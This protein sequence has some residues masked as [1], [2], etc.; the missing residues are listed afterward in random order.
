MSNDKV[1]EALRTSMK[2][3]ERLRKQNQELTAAAREPIA[4]VAMACR[5]PGGVR[6]PE[7]L[8]DL[9]VGERDAITEFPVNRGW[10]LDS[11][12]NDDPDHEGTSYSRE[13]GFLHDAGSFDPELFGISPREA[14]AMDPQQRL[15]LETS[16][17]SF[18][19][20]G[21]DPHSLRGNRCGVFVGLS[22][23]D[24]ATRLRKA[25]EGTEGHLLTGNAGAVASGRLSY[26]FG[27]E[28][29]AVTVDTACSSSLVALHLACQAL[30]QGDCSMALAGGVTVMASPAAFVAFSRQRG[31]AANGRCK[32]FS[33]Y[34]DGTGWSEG[35]G[36]VLVERLS[37]ARRN[38]HPVLAVVRGTGVN[39]DGASSGLTAPNGPSQQRVIKQ[40]LSNA[41]LS[42]SDVDAVE[43]HGTGTVLGD[44]IEAQ[45]VLATY[46]Q[47]RSEDHPLWL[48]SLKS[49][50]GHAQGAAGVAGVIK[51]VLATQHGLLPKTLHV[52]EP[53]PQVD[54]TAGS[55]R[56]LTEAMPW[57]DT[58]RPRRAGVSSFG[59]SGTNAHA[60]VEQAPP[61]GAAEREP[62]T[63][64]SPIVAWPVSGQTENGLR[65]QADRLAGYLDEHPELDPV[66]VG[67][68]L[69]TTRAA[70]NHRAVV[71]AAN[72]EDF[73]RAL[74]ALAEGEPAPEVVRGAKGGGRFAIQF[75]GQGSQR[76]G[77]GRELHAT[78]PVFAAAFDDVCAHLDLHLDRPVR[79]VV[80][81]ADEELANQTAYAQAGLFAVEVALFRLVEH[82]GVLPKLLLGHSIGE[83][84][85]AHVS[86][87]LS[88][89]DACALVA[90]RGRLMQALPS[91]GAMVSL[92]AS[93]DEVAP[94]LDETVSIAAVNGPASVVVSGDED[95]VSRIAEHFAAEGR[96]TKRLRVSHAFHSPRMDAMLAEFRRAA[97]RVSFEPP[98]IPIVSNVTGEVATAEQ[99][100]S[101]GYWVD[102][103]RRAVRFRDGIRTLQA[104]G[105]TSLLELGPGGVLS[106]MGP[107]CL[108]E[109]GADEVA[110]VP[111]L[112]GG[113]PEVPALLRAIGELHVRGVSPDWRKFYAGS[114]AR[115]VDLP[116]YAF[117]HREFWLE[118]PA[119]ELGDLSAA[120]LRSAEH[121]L[122]GAA[123]SLADAEGVV[124]LGR[125]SLR[126]HPWLAD[127]AILGSVLLPGTAFVELA[128]RAGDQVGCDLV[129][130][131]TLEAPLVLGADSAVQVQLS[132]GVPDGTGRRTVTVYSREEDGFEGEWTRHATGVLATATSGE[133]TDLS[134]WPPEGAR[135]LELDGFYDRLTESGF[136][137]GPVF[138]GLRAAW[139]RG[140]EI[141]AE[142]ALPE[143]ARAD[144]ARFGLHPGLLDAA[145]HA[146]GLEP[147]GGAGGG[148]LPFAWTGVR[149][150]ASGASSL[151]VRLSA[152]SGD[153]V[154]IAVADGSGAPVASVDALVLRPVTA[155]Q[156]DGAKGRAHRNLF[157]VDW[158]TATTTSTVDVPEPR[159][160][161]AVLGSVAAGDELP[162]V[163]AVSVNGAAGAEATTARV[164]E[165]VKAWLAA[166]RDSRLV[167]V[168]RGAVAVS[169]DAEVTDLG[170]S[171]VWGLVRAAQSEHP[172]R[173]TLVD[174]DAESAPIVVG[175]EPQVAVRGGRALVPRLVRA[176]ELAQPAAE[177]S[178]AAGGTVLVTGAGGGLGA[179]VARHV[180]AE[181]G[182]R[183][184]VLISR[185]GDRAPGAAELSAE[186]AGLGAE[187]V[188]AACDVADRDA[189]AGV[190]AAV[191]DERPL[192]GVV[193]AAGIVDDGLVGSLS[194]ERLFAVLRPKVE[195]AWNLHELTA[196]L[197]LSAFVLFSSAAGV[198]G[199]A[200][201]ANYAAANAFLDALAQH[202]RCRGLVATSLAWG[203][204]GHSGG[205]AGELSEAD[206]NRMAR[207]GVVPL[208]ADEGLELFDIGWRSAE[209]FL[210]P[211]GL[212]VTALRNR[213]T[214]DTVPPLLRNLIR[215]PARRAVTAEPGSGSSL[216]G[217]LHGLPEGE[218]GKVLLDL[219]RTQVAVVL[220]FAGAEAVSASRA[221]SEIGFDSLTAV[222]LRNRLNSVTGLR[223]P[224]T[225]IFDYP[226]P[227]VLAEFL[228]AE[229][230][231]EQAEVAGP[232]AT[233]AADGEPIA[234]VGMACRYPGGVTS[235]EDLWEL[236]FS[237]RDGITEFPVNRGWDL[238]GLYDADA[239][240][241]GTSYA[242]EGG[243]L[244]DAAEFDPAF[245]G[246]SPREAVAM[247]PQ[248]RLLLETSWE[249]F[250]RA[251]IDPATVRGSRTGVFTGVMYHD[252]AARL[253]AFPEG[254]EGYL[255]TGNAGSVASGRVSYAF[256][257]EGPAVTVD[258]ACSSSLV[259][260]H[261]AVQALRSGEC[262]LALAGGVTVMSTP[263]TFV[264]FSRQRGLARDGRCKSFAAA[265]DGTG[266]SEGVGVLLVERLSD[267]R[268]NGHPVLAVV[269]G[270]AIN[271][272]GASN[273][274][275]APNGPSQQRVIRQALAN[276]GL[277]PS[278][279][280]A[281]E[282]HGTGTVLGDPIEAQAL[283]ATYG[284]DRDE[285]L[286]LGSIKS[287]LGHSQAAAGVAGVIKMVM[288][289]RH[290]TLPRTP[291]V[292]EPSPH[293]DWSSGA[294]ELLTE[295]R[296]WQANGRPRRAGVSSFGISGTNA[297]VVLEQIEE[298][299]PTPA[300][301]NP[302]VLP[303][304]VSGNDEAA[305][306]AQA[307][308][309]LSRV[310]GDTA[311]LDVAFSLAT[312]RASFERRAVVVGTGQDELLAG[313]AA[314]SG[315]EAAQGLVEGVAAE[316]QL[317]FLFSGQGSQRLGMGREL[318]AAFPVF[319]EAFDE[320][321]AELDRHL[322]RSLREVIWGEDSELVDQTGYTQPG[323]FAV[324]VAL[325]RLVESWGVRPDYLLGHSI[326]ELAAAHVADVFSLADAARLVV[327]RGRLMQALPSGGAMVAVQAT[328]DDV[329]PLL[330]DT[331]S[332]AAINGPASVVV[333][334]DESAAL[335]VAEHFEAEGRKTKRLRVSHAFH[336]PRM[337]P[338]LA[339]FAEVAASVE[340]QAPRI[341]V[342]SNVSGQLDGE[343]A[344]P[345]Y[346]VRHVR[347]A[348]RFADG[349]RTL[350]ERGVTAFLEIGPDGVLTGLAQESL[351]ES[352]LVPALRRDRDEARALVEALG[353]LHVNG[354]AVD[355]AAWFSGSGARRIDLPTYAFQRRR[356]WLEEPAGSVGDVASAGLAAAGHPLLGAAVR[357]AERD[358]VV[359]TGRVSVRTH[360]WLAE[361]VV[362]GA[363]VVPGT[364]L[365]DMAV[366]A[367]DQI[368]CTQVA[369]LTL[370]AP[371]L[372]P[373]EGAVQLQLAV[374]AGDESGRHNLSLHARIDD[375]AGEQ[376]WTLHATGTLATGRPESPV[377][378]AAWPP[379]E[380]AALPVDEVYR[381]AAAAG[382]GYGP[383]FQGLRAVWQ[384]GEEIFAEVALPEH[385]DAG[386]F[387]LHPA[388]FDAVL[389]AL[390][391]LPGE[392]EG[393]G[394]LPFSW[395]G[396]SLHASGASALRARLS[397]TGT[398]SIA[399]DLADPTGQPVAT[400]GALRLRPV[401]PD[402][403]RAAETTRNRSLF[404]VDWDPIAAEP[405][406]FAEPRDL[407]TVLG[408]VAAGDELPEVVAVPV[409]GD[410]GAAETAAKVLELVKAWLAADGDARLVFVTSGAVTA[411]RAE[412]VADLGA[413][414]VWGLVRAA[415]SEHP[416]R[417]ALVDLDSAADGPV[418]VVPGEPQVAVRD[419]R[420]LAPRL[421]RARELAQPAAEVSFA[422]GGTVL[423]S[424]AGGGWG[425]LVAR[426]VVAE[427]GVRRLVLVSR[428][429]DG[430]PGAAE[431]SAELAGLGAEVVWAACDV[432]DR[433]ALAGVLAGIPDERPLIGVVH[434]A[435]IVDDG[436]V[437]SLSSERLAAVL[438]PKVEGARNL[439]E[440]T[441]GLDLSAFVLF[442]SVAGVFGSAGQANYAAANAYL[443]ALAQHRRCRGLVATSL[444]WGLWGHSGGMA[445][446][447]TEAD[448][449][450]M[451]RDGVHALTA[452]Q[453][454][455]L[456]DIGWR[457]AEAHLVPVGLDLLALRNRLT[458]DEVP[459]LL[460]GLIRLPA[461]RHSAGSAAADTT[462]ARRL[463]GLTAEEQ[464][465]AVVA[466]I[467]A[468]VAVVLGFAGAEAVSVSRAFSEIGFDSLTAVELRN[469]LNSVTGLRLPATLIFDYPTPLL[470]AEFVRSELVGDRV[471]VAGPVATT[472]ADDEPIAIVGMA[473][474]YPGGVSSP[475][476]LW[477]FV[478]AGGDGISA[479][480]TDRG[481]DLDGLYDADADRAGTS[482]AREGG[483]L[484]DAAEFDP[485]FF[486][487]S[488]RE[489][490][491]MDPQQRLLLETSWEA[492]ERAGID[493]ESLRGSRTGVFAGVMYSDYSARLTSVPQGVEGY[494]GTGTSAS[495]LSGRVSYT[496]G[497]E[498]PAVTVDTA[499]SSSL[500]ALHLAA[501][502][503]RSG[504]CSLAL[505]GGVTV[506]ATPGAFVEFSRQ[507]GL[508]PDGR[509]RSF[510][511][512]AD[513]VGWSEGVGVLLVER[514]SDA[515]R[516]GHQVLG[517]VRGS[518]VNQDG[519]SNGLTA[520]NGPSQQRVIRQAVASAGLELSDVDAVEAHGTGTVLG[521][522]IEAQ[523]LI[524]TYGQDREQPLWLGS[525]KSNIGHS[526]AAAG[527]AGIIKMV[528]AMRHGVLPKSLHL[529][530]P[531]P[532]VDWSAGAVELLTE[533]R[534]WPETGRA[535]R[536]AVSSFGISGTN[537][538]V[539][540]EQAPEPVAEV[541][542]G[543]APPVLPWV[544][545]AKTPEALT[546]QADRLNTFVP[547]HSPV[548]VG[549]SLAT[550]RS[551]LERRAVVVG[552][553]AEEL[554]RGLTALAQGG[555]APGVRTGTAR[556]GG[557]AVL[558]SGQGSQRLGMGRELYEAFPVFAEAFDAVCAGL[559]EHLEEPL[560]AVIWGA[561]A[562]AVHQT[563]Y[564][565]AGLFAVEVALFRLFE[566]FGV[567]P[568]YL[569]GHSIGELAAAHVAGVLALESA[570]AL[571][572][573][574]GR[575]M[576]ALPTGGAMVAVQ[577]TED[578][579]VPL[580]DDSV[581]IAAVNGPASVVVSGAEDA[582]L[583]VAERFE[584]RKTRRLR[585]SHAFHSALMEPMLAEFRRVA[586]GLTFGEPRIPLVSNVSG[587]VA[588]A[589]ELG[590]PGYWVDHVRRAVRFAEGVESL[591][592][593]GVSTF[594]E[595]GPAGVLAGM[596]QECLAEAGAE[597]GVVA[598]L[599]KDRPE[600]VALVE[601]LAGVF[602]RGVRVD[603]PVLFAGANARRVDLPTYPFQRRRYWLDAG[604][605]VSDASAAGL[606]V[607]GHPL[608]SAVVQS[609]DSDAVVLT[610]RL[611][612]HTHA[613]L[614]DHA[615]FGR[616]LVPG[617]GLVELA[618]R[619]GQQVGCDV[620]EE[621]TLRAPLTLPERGGLAVQVVVD[622]GDDSGRR[623]VHV[624]SR[625]ENSD[626]AWTLH[627]EGV[628]GS[629]AAASFELTEWPPAG[630]EAVAVEGAY[631][632]FAEQGYGYGP[633]FRG[634]RAVWRRGAELFAEVVLPERARGDAER[635]GL[636]PALLDAAMH[637]TLGGEGGSGDTV[638][639]FAWNGV[640]L[641]A[642]GA[643]AVRVRLAP[644]PDGGLRIAVADEAGQPVLS[645]DSMVGRPVSPEQLRAGGQG[646]PLYGVDW[647]PVAHGEVPQQSFVEWDEVPESGAVPE[648]VVLECAAPEDQVPDAV[649]SVLHRVL[650]AVQRWLADERFAGSRLVVLTRNAVATEPG[651]AVRLAEAPVWGLVRAAQAEN[652]GRFV[653][654][655]ADDE[656]AGALLPA[657]V[658][659]GEP[660]A[661][662]RAGRVHLPRLVRL[663]AA[664]ANPVFGATGTVLVT[665]GTG[666]LGALVARH[667]V[668]VHGVRRL[669]LTS[670]RGLDAP[671]AGELAAELAE[672][673]AEVEV[674]ACDVADREAVAALVA[675]IPDLDAVVHA[676]GIGDNGLVSALSPERVDAVLAPKADAAWYLHELTRGLDLSAFVLF[677]SAGG[678]V[679]AAG[680]ANYAAA[681]V[682]L[683]ALAAQRHADG[684]P[685]TSLA[686]G[687][688]DSGSGMGE[689]LGE[690]DRQRM[691]AQ[692]LPPLPVESALALFDAGL[693][694]DRPVVVPVRVDPS[695]L[696]SR[697]GEIPALLRGLAP[698]VRR[699][700]TAASTETTLEQRLAGLGG[701]ERQRVL[702]DLV[703]SRVAG[704]LG[705]A[706]AESIEPDRA[707][708]E[709]GFDSLAAMELRNQ[710]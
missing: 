555:T 151:R 306:R 234:I 599:R 36:M 40:A 54:W 307:A 27:L 641:F 460:R 468:E 630:A 389:H 279:V 44:P 534:A 426:H 47:G 154:A 467:A 10:D 612:L 477:D 95:A 255:G 185:R 90:A 60:I 402:Q 624:F 708:Q 423:G 221:F 684:L 370:H 688:W 507:R 396:V 250:E 107:D 590:S 697:E 625:A 613:W 557:L 121:P 443:D 573:A 319:A 676:A 206:L 157:R 172:D 80:W 414:A 355:W 42:P 381:R 74:R 439:H 156:L 188:W 106:G 520:P 655:D 135:R 529:D 647:K 692:G 212:D 545:S 115:R 383:L 245:F 327:A 171:A 301:P 236:V 78:Y 163:V 12:Y 359:L 108:D 470:L 478:L 34:A 503:L 559:D 610:G 149:L 433:D 271:Q 147:S 488:P 182:V 667:L 127:H 639:P 68:S 380:A 424:G 472:A 152:A 239:D 175:S 6:S 347:E 300:A 102:H 553:D 704:V 14:L 55:V 116:P 273:G 386:R 122:L 504:E 522:P 675:R 134:V 427:H 594:V 169:A 345:E 533:T 399:L 409:G 348:V 694:A 13:G 110:F 600:A 325:F 53:T 304:L 368:G 651:A 155:Q 158:D 689:G 496:F 693:A 566:S 435:G 105:V 378:L 268:K 88:L 536:A 104:Q 56:L 366:H 58:G 136:G 241:A 595:L 526:Q 398:D 388:L 638:I 290:E 652:P 649:R 461:R 543:Q 597:V 365:L 710:L 358:E 598:G 8:W 297:H 556:P 71:A 568:D 587:R 272:D 490:L 298:P 373:E 678:L 510:S 286:W 561:D 340:Y 11:L 123:V 535:R 633:V 218:Q 39:Q 403:I 41:G 204:W 406:I 356:Y 565:Q 450:R 138:Q 189:L 21:I 209:P 308:R 7:D 35:V 299:E 161:A 495:V 256:G 432:A 52:T 376:P 305:L 422:A 20:A 226:T 518:A 616:V 232:V 658:A 637:P 50:V 173:F 440:L 514:L 462:L 636:H 351:D 457:S 474:R 352:V 260:L 492:F 412:D 65:G 354:I 454:L 493:P 23:H 357:L 322:D 254:V 211:A 262:G 283:L 174:V 119:E 292:D 187:V 231:G 339:E 114:G 592:G 384:R 350:A 563:Q 622:A 45:A 164:L 663:P 481:W 696:R 233:T 17:E 387:G 385:A 446:E 251:G 700:A 702:L 201:Q 691:R 287:N 162:D 673:G 438:R 118:A 97:E 4:I 194:S 371:L 344:S 699:A 18:E 681:N 109:P 244:H 145:L 70:L 571:V 686:F 363:I 679:L 296:P 293:I 259:A 291:H 29:P 660:E 606:G 343:L 581:S 558:F 2:E 346:W 67:F 83:L 428:R 552:T 178:F 37:D 491:A 200:G 671:G 436:L 153:A 129:E 614:A 223:L 84:T 525:I 643:A 575:L 64:S 91:G 444:A 479:F 494:L 505:A 677:S 501:Q 417:F 316:R 567:R 532:H 25:P 362:A 49:N 321:C 419:G 602:V 586:E 266:W 220:G 410:A 489:A 395:T 705:H 455:E 519:A 548:D 483:F 415:Q 524:A 202:R 572:A 544:L 324:E 540:V 374:G 1:L 632:R 333:S 294:V 574:R 498:G 429:G 631:E 508:A 471:E 584:G 323:L 167:F 329:A 186:L 198:F 46:G 506:M 560:R 372:V 62:V 413:S 168:T 451:A 379:E 585:V 360:E 277:R 76:L 527:V 143:G 336:S 92:Q 390:A 530:E 253:R 19:R 448:L 583:A 620:V 81:G 642:V 707:F 499:C 303:W 453:G 607:A 618:L 628:L 30:R 48:G 611:S 51:M 516:N 328:E 500:V 197:D 666:G 577:A 99:L 331:V 57:P 619:A 159:E 466:A 685:A 475:D 330:E 690:I 404:R 627:A 190:L 709:L 100:C 309:L 282:A 562:E 77:M 310:D 275:T 101:P 225:L 653:L 219:V 392:G 103:V 166:D 656:G 125:I 509:C 375:P 589:A 131:L 394:Q 463:A 445:G 215:V 112:R 132:V 217:D 318:Y 391:A 146:M 537:A 421:A 473:C 85:A 608:L 361:H 222:E 634:M 69:A 626:A 550:T 648:V 63:V 270:T 82:W 650:E 593:A 26:T 111:A 469:R 635:F 208:T 393:G 480:P 416:D 261:W 258:T 664:E 662:I 144:A 285:P 33:A 579:V 280:D 302:P 659:S 235:P 341:P 229:L 199:G 93:E 420:L 604:T 192:T 238:D 133:G 252:Y 213:L 207:D 465:A 265:A 320:V 191:P 230:V 364:A 615:V 476:E 434:A 487:I 408:A 661:A 459:P 617:T 289:M 588:T 621:L 87:V 73:R 546:E 317:G 3:A 486:G 569:L 430:A 94:L 452:E 570:C 603:W 502:A 528:Q 698:A 237:G 170:A 126:S 214:G 646:D 139:R 117:D 425:A 79:E 242:R 38:G 703:R 623:S 216:A 227:A 541:A 665:G 644:A 257:L 513:G 531:S 150:F 668:A 311:P 523:A 431:L 177:V 687:L 521:D 61:V 31:L 576:Q 342:V 441:A 267:A 369:E 142:V 695:A 9:V 98:R 210:V 247:D 442:S 89:P 205:M 264:D 180:V 680:Q 276:A 124:L 22:Y 86:G 128:V 176:R 148:R 353:R 549:W 669:V 165:L 447:L 674:V 458:G 130:E 278:D 482:Y 228:R 551:A 338:M 335:R 295:A 141:F 449:N 183:H 72:R 517:V 113:T 547:G 591:R 326:G 670:R 284:Q 184:V 609:P 497:L 281:V 411:G 456:F 349:V 243:F 382:F 196:G 334:G 43:A 288:A 5:L 657:V 640:S 605:G 367:A 59:V 672:S 418:P 269:R 224:A 654:V 120:G 405:A 645:V 582:V 542:A 578:E 137:Y 263:G 464:T 195:G 96:K 32:A 538:H 193:H 312:T 313:L 15:L 515:R 512:S 701:A 24:Y 401:A 240:R 181:H 274:L 160:L 407:E 337:D 484:H 249:A 564:A 140:D 246:I 66:D 539:V 248:Q 179:L 485:A 629:G 682:F 315:G 400:V 554:T 203:L 580:L 683:D 75:S 596:A 332:I 28:G 397:P 437:G 511:A 601:A 706:S 377:E 314:L 16:W